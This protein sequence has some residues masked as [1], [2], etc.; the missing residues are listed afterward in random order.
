MKKLCATGPGSAIPVVSMMTRSNLSFPESR[1]SF[2]SPR[3]RIRSPRTVQHTQ[4]LFISMICSPVPVSR[5]SLS[6]PASP[7]SFSITAM[8]RPCRSLRTRLMSVVLPLPRK[9]VSMVTG[10]MFCC[11]ANPFSLRLAQDSPVGA[12]PGAKSLLEIPEKRAHYNTPGITTQ[13]PRRGFEDRP[14][15]YVYRFSTPLKEQPLQVLPFRKLDQHRVVR[16]GGKA[17]LQHERRAGIRGGA[18]DD[19]LEQLRRHAPRAGKSRKQPAGPKQLQRVQ[20]DVL[21][22]ARG[23]RGVLRGRRE[24]GR[25]EHHQV[26]LP[27]LALQSAQGLEHVGLE[28]LGTA[29]LKPVE[30]EV[31]FCRRERG[32][33]AVDRE[34][35]ARAAGK[36]RKRETARVAEAIE[37]LPAGRK[38]PD[39][40][41]I[42]ALVEIEPGLLPRNDVD[43]VLDSMLEDPDRSVGL[44]AGHGTGARSKAFHFPRPRVGTLVHPGATGYVAQDLDKRLAPSFAACRD[45]LHDQDIGVAVGDQARKAVGFAVDQPERI[46]RLRRNRGAT[47][48]ERR[49][50]L[51]SE[52]LRSRDFGFVEA[53]HACADLRGRAERRPG[54]ESAVRGADLHVGAA[55]RRALHLADRAGKDP[56]MAPQKRALAAGFQRQFG[57]IAHELRRAFQTQPG[58]PRSPAATKSQRGWILVVRT[59]AAVT[60]VIAKATTERSADSV[61]RYPP[62]SISPTVTGTRP[63]STATRHGAWRKRRQICETPKVSRHEGPHTAAVATRAPASPATFQPIRLTTRMF[64]PGEAW[65]SAKRSANCAP[66]I[67]PWTSTTLRC[68]S[69]ST[70]TAPPT[71][72]SDR[73]EKSTASWARGPSLTLLSRTPPPRRAA[74]PRATRRP[75]ASA[76]ARCRRKSLRRRAPSPSAG[77][78]SPPS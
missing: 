68:I 51:L 54:E 59:T 28:P 43:L 72:S 35:R 22:A 61:M 5:M 10:T 62:A 37:H 71:A 50:D 44:R 15:Y 20:V 36:R 76:P 29:R 53:P 25:V 63:A 39:A 78:G 77:G 38:K 73:M 74:Q 19:L 65:A 47:K 32:G 12:L 56:R 70:V 67:Q 2:N 16:R 6:T 17:L 1:R 8:R 49:F 46:A 11:S 21:V 60:A 41:A 23:A 48:R 33:R 34:H 42:V 14:L 7:S 18:G 45:D 24:L 30:R 9:P 57:R 52:Q 58:R 26:E 13:P 31:A 40:S 69:G 66:L 27:A 3:M 55:L 4:P 64:G 75:G